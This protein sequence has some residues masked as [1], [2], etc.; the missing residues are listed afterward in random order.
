LATKSLESVSSSPKNV[1]PSS[2]LRTS[3]HRHSSNLITLIPEK[4]TPASRLARKK[5]L[6]APHTSAVKQVAPT[7]DCYKSLSIVT[8]IKEDMALNIYFHIGNRY[9]CVMLHNYV[10]G[11]IQQRSFFRRCLIFYSK[12]LYDGAVPFVINCLRQ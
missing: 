11:L 12:E 9:F 5:L 8:N 10:S 4:L 3:M 1:G 2:R 6:C 7:T